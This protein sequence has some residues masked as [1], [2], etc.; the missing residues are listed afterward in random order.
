M[1]FCVIFF[2]R[3]VVSSKKHLE[4]NFFFWCGLRG[5][6]FFVLWVLLF[7]LTLV[8]PQV[9]QQYQER[10]Q[11]LAPWH[12]PCFFGSTAGSLGSGM[13]VVGEMFRGSAYW[14]FGF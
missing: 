11:L 8:E 2:S 6:F 4:S 1:D 7:S 3:S 13:M 10:I 9:Q 5:A 12:W 14:G